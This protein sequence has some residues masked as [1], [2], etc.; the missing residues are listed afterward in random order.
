M[1]MFEQLYKSIKQHT[2]L[3]EEEWEICKT[4][5]IPKR[6]RKRQYLLQ[7][8]DVCRR[9]AFI[10]K[11][12]LFSYSIDEKGTQKV[13]QFGFEGWWIAD[14]YSF[15]TNEPSTLNI[16]AL[17]DCELLLIE[18]EE[19]EELIQQV[20]AIGNYHRILFQNAFVALQRRVEHT[21]GSTAEEKYRT[22]IEEFP[23]SFFNRIPQH[24]IAS[25]LGIT[26][27]TLSRVRNLRSVRK[28]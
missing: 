24:L 10:E 21:I 26:P 12:A 20:P 28:T 19:H 22:L 25:Y 14:L 18:K 15:L 11:G 4:K 6:L 9:L 8:D 7:Q 27:E 5:F 17:E 13:I 1:A 23:H 3:T 16:E 2:D